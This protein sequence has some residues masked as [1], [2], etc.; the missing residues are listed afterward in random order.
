[1]CG[2]VGVAG[3]LYKSHVDAFTDLLWCDTL[4]GSDSTGVASIFNSGEVKYIKKLGTPVELFDSYGFKDV[5]AMNAKCIIGHNRSATVGG[6]SRSNA[7]PFIFDSIVGAHNG[8]VDHASKMRMEDGGQFG[9]DSEAI[10][11][12]IDK[13]GID[14]TIPKLDGAWC[15]V[16]Y[17]D[18]DKTINFIRN[19]KR[20]LTYAFSKDRKQ[21]FWASEAG[22][23]MWILHRNN[24]DV[25][26]H[27]SLRE[28]TLHSFTLP[29]AYQAK[30]ED[31]I[32][33]KIE[34]VKKET[35][36]TQPGLVVFPQNGNN[37]SS[38]GSAVSIAS[39][40]ASNTQGDSSPPTNEEIIDAINGVI[41]DGVDWWESM[42]LCGLE[43]EV[44]ATK[45][46]IWGWQLG[47]TDKDW[48]ER[49]R[50]L[51]EDGW[52]WGDLNARHGEKAP[53]PV[54]EKPVARVLKP[55]HMAHNPPIFNAAKTA[56]WNPVARNW[57]TLPII[58][59]QVFWS[60]NKGLW[61][62]RKADV[63]DRPQ[64]ITQGN[65]TPAKKS[66]VGQ[67]LD[68]FE[69]Y[70]KI[71]EK[72][73]AGKRLSKAEQKILDDWSDAED[74][75]PFDVDKIQYEDYLAK[76]KQAEDNVVHLASR[77]YKNPKTRAMMTE[78]EFKTIAQHGCD[79]C[80]APVSWGDKCQFHQADDGTIE[81]FCEPCLSRN[82]EVQDY[83]RMK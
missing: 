70:K 32:T 59:C 72:K 10:F 53:P 37:A 11:N 17:N 31:P 77:V 64:E 75:P 5:V 62:F 26:K 4:R 13:H 56:V 42:I 47:E 63:E 1:M 18:E 79:W 12:N 28:D 40:P 68:E 14:E 50:D 33:R 71:E 35:Q 83:L 7:H 6:R 52:Q 65:K 19:D 16:F 21:L 73:A 78:A 23:L 48:L 41:R 82:N 67:L 20:P 36:H 9:T 60:P 22:M 54:V 57:Q 25:E 44:N 66:P 8:T 49:V 69:S 29:K 61:V 58:G 51:L 24:I 34:G 74:D 45:E 2:L 27:V 3:D 15:L 76:K 55:D 39:K 38:G 80:T 81:V 46:E 30:F 43:F